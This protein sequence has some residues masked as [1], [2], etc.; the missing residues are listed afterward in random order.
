M[1]RYMWINTI[2]PGMPYNAN[3]ESLFDMDVE[4]L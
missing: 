4:P 1:N 2:D 3:E